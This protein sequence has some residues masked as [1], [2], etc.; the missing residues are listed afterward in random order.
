MRPDVRRHPRPARRHGA[1]RAPVR[2]ASSATGRALHATAMSTCCAMRWRWTDS[3][4]AACTSA[5]R[6]ARSTRR[7]M[8]ATR[9]RRSCAIYR[10]SSRNRRRRA[11]FSLRSKRAIQRRA[12]PFG[13][14]SPGS[15]A[16][17][18]RG[19]VR[20]GA[21]ARRRRDGVRFARR[22][23]RAPRTDGLPAVQPCECEHERGREHDPR[24]DECDE[25]CRQA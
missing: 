16:P 5:R 3:T 7:P 2:D 1:L 15:A 19:R 20:R 11:A 22:R 9:G 21:A 4:R 13:I 10:R 14:A 8:P 18:Q 6:A 24:R 12:V 23:I 17:S 25:Q